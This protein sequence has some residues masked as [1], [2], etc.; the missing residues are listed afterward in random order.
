MKNIRE[1]TVGLLAGAWIISSNAYATGPHLIEKWKSGN[2]KF[3][4]AQLARLT[5]A[6]PFSRAF[7]VDSQPYN[8]TIY[9]A[10]GKTIDISNSTPSRFYFQSNFRVGAVIVKA[11]R[12]INWYGPNMRRH[13]IQAPNGKDISHFTFCWR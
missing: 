12:N 11:G 6:E 13:W 3:E 7:K 8:G 9:N 4:C 5:G 2:A 1:L 10:G